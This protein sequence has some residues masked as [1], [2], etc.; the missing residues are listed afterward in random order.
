MFDP[1]NARSRPR[2][3][4]PRDADADRSPAPRIAPH[5]SLRSCE[6]AVAAEDVPSLV[7]KYELDPPQVTA[8]IASMWA[9]HLERGGLPSPHKKR[10]RKPNSRYDQEAIAYAEADE[11]D[12]E[13]EVAE[14]E[15]EEE[16]V[17]EATEDASGH[18][19]AGRKHLD[20]DDDEV[21]YDEK[22][23][24]SAEVRVQVT[25]GDLRGTIVL[26]AGYKK[27]QEFV[28]YPDGRKVPPSQ[29]ERDA[30]KGSSKSWKTSVFVVMPDGSEGR[31]FRIWMES[32]G[33]FPK[34][35]PWDESVVEAARAL[36]GKRKKV[37]APAKPVAKKSKPPAVAAPKPKTKTA[38][39]AAEKE[40]KAA[41]KAPEKSI[42]ETQLENLL[43]DDGGLRLVEKTPNFVWLMRNALKNV[44]R[45]LV[46]TVIHRTTDKKCAEAFVK[47]EG[48]KVLHEWCAK[49]KEENKS[50]L[51]LKMLKTFRRL[52]MTVEVLSSTGLGNFVNKLRKYKPPGKEDDDLTNQVVQEAERVKNKWVSVVRAESEAAEKRQAAE[53]AA[54]KAAK[55]PN[56]DANDQDASKRRKVVVS[57]GVAAVATPARGAEETKP[58]GTT[59]T[60]KR[61]PK[62]E[63]S[64]PPGPGPAPAPAPAPVPAATRVGV[65]KPPGASKAVTGSTTTI[66]RTTTTISRPT[67]STM[68]SFG[69]VNV[70]GVAAY[71]KEPTVTGLASKGSAGSSSVGSASGMGPASSKPP[72]EFFQKSTFAKKKSSKLAAGKKSGIGWRADEE[73]EAVKF[74][75]K[76]D[77]VGNAGGQNGVPD[78]AEER[79]RLAQEKREA[80]RK[81]REEEEEVEDEDERAAIEKARE[82]QQKEKAAEQRAA[83]LTRTRRLNEM[84]AQ[85]R[86]SRPGRI[87]YP[88]NWEIY[89]G[90]DSE[91]RGR[92]QT[93]WE[94]EFEVKYRSPDQIPE[95]PRE[96]P[97]HAAYDAPFADPPTMIEVST[98]APP[99]K[100][101]GQ[102]AAAAAHGGHQHGGHQQP[103]SA[104]QTFYPPLPG[105]PPPANSMGVAALG[106]AAQNGGAGG[107]GGFDQSALQALLQSV[108]SGALK[109]PPTHA[110]GHPHGHQPPL[111]PPGAV[112]Y[113]NGVAPPPHP[114]GGA[115]GIGAGMSSRSYSQGGPPPGLGGPGVV[116]HEPWRSDPTTGQKG[117]MPGGNGLCAFF[118]TPKGCRWGDACRFR[119]ERGP[120]PPPGAFPN[121]RF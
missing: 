49:A 39:A 76:D 54:E 92:L 36:M 4:E 28:I 59:G 103:A 61:D 95:S 41:E 88:A 14:E 55:R 48:I 86:W 40:K 85:C 67:T 63:G 89:P 7:E 58:P 116:N 77:V 26:P 78:P 114:G 90:K 37:A 20:D 105:G 101:G 121:R 53:N 18:D 32:N 75:F 43:D 66:A 22:T 74:F 97:H 3:T 91:E 12:E 23:G 24:I 80:A 68:S 2:L 96:A 117:P 44:E 35:T 30:G 1:A 87:E 56:K 47:S 38:A 79:R 104:Q 115:A 110:A 82:R 34:G 111:P 107:R 11:E 5:R 98:R 81:D 15:D 119:H 6:G 71:R 25:C 21:S 83:N 94:G 13:E 52:P 73:L 62:V 45:S 17:A 42:F 33:Y 118:N 72:K 108:Q 16:E 31:A 106:S 102:P 70:R 10:E 8:V 9:K 120:A 64:K 109:V 60:T 51:V 57:S 100:D 84:K 27:Q 112:P 50:S 65:P 113:G 69:G 93:R 19:A 46:V 99:R 29:F